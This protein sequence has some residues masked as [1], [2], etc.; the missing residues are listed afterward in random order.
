VNKKLW[1]LSDVDKTIWFVFCTLRLCHYS[2]LT[3]FR[4][5]TD[6]TSDLEEEQ[7]QCRSAGLRSSIE[8]HTAQR[9]S[10]K[11]ST[12][13]EMNLSRVVSRLIAFQSNRPGCQ[14]K[15]SEQLTAAINQR[16]FDD[17]TTQ[18]TVGGRNIC[19]KI[20]N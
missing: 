6:K 16:P 12:E 20:F 13:H 17:F 7:G 9:S 15:K 10:K 1:H 5:S 8:L 14:K 2:Q 19:V 18:N 3:L 4:F 11:V